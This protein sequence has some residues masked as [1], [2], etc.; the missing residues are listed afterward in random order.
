[1]SAPWRQLKIELWADR[2][3]WV[4]LVLMCSPLVT[5]LFAGVLAIALTM[6]FGAM[7]AAIGMTL[8]LAER[9]CL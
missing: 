4:G 6:Y 1:M 7:I 2:L 8:G 9:S 3:F 5:V